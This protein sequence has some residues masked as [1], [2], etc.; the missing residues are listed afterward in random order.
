MSEL[1]LG[2]T[3]EAQAALEQATQKDP[4]Y[5]EAIANALVLQVILGKDPKEQIEYVVS[6]RTH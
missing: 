1:H 6:S 3:E 5:V 4:S 2:R